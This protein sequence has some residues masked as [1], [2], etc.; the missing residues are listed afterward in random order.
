MGLLQEDDEQYGDAWM[1]EINFE[2][3]D[4]CSDAND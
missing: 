2:V 3:D 1:E 4:C